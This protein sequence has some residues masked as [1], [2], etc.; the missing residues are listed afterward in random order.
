MIKNY[1]KVAFRILLRNKV[2]S[3]I[4]IVGL[5]VGLCSSII[6]YLYVAH[7]LSFEKFHQDSNLIYRFIMLEED[8][9]NV[10]QHPYCRLPLSPALKNDFPEI[11]ESVRVRWGSIDIAYQD[12]IFQDIELRYVDSSFLNVFSF[13]MFQGD[14][15]NALK[16]PTSLVL[17]E[18]KA[19]AIFGSE[20]PM[21]KTVR[22]LSGDNFVVRG[23]IQDPPA[24]TKF[25]FEA[26]A[27]V[28]YFK[29]SYFYNFSWNGG[30]EFNTF[31][32]LHKNTNVKDLTSKFKSF[33]EKHNKDEVQDGYLQPVRDMHLHSSGLDFSDGEKR[34]SEVILFAVIALFILF[35]AI[36]NY[37]NL[38]TARSMERA[39]E[40]GI[41]KVVGAH[42]LILIRQFFAESYLLVLLSVFLALIFVEIFLPYVNIVLKENLSLYMRSSINVV[43]ILIQFFIIV[44][45]LSA[46]YPAIYLSSFNPI[47]VLKG[48][49]SSKAKSKLR[50]VLV[51]FQFLIASVLISVTLYSV[52]QLTFILSKDK[53]YSD[54]NVVVVRLNSLELRNN[55][56]DIKGEMESIPGIVKTSASSA[57]PGYGFTA[58][59][60]VPE[61]YTDYILIKLLRIDEDYFETMGMEITKG[62]AFSEN[63][64][65]EQNKFIINETLV[66][67]LGWK[68]PIGKTISRNGKKYTVIGVVKDFHFSSLQQKIEPLIISVEVGKY[69]EYFNLNIKINENNQT[70][71]INEIEKIML[72]MDESRIFEHFYLDSLKDNVY[73]QERSFN[74]LFQLFSILAICIA[75]LGLYG[76]AAYT[77]EQRIKEIG[78][79]KALGASVS[80]LL[81][82]LSSQ[83]F[84]VLIISNAIA[85]P[86]VVYLIQSWQD[87]YAYF[88]SISYLDFLIS[89][90]ISMLIAAGIVGFISKKVIKQNPVEALKYE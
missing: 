74:R 7:H 71:T 46:I 50:T 72:R 58:N 11:E 15:L 9:G 35:I 13:E 32:K 85:I 69:F 40:V 12:K 87:N 6:I 52:R 5:A 26:I 76:L 42:R 79:R 90:F 29:D 14:F 30:P 38:S 68:D 25:Q 64:K 65:A 21:G 82:I 78:I 83:Y 41:K 56:K 51:V 60:Y 88:V 75:C 2:F 63:L 19:K 37:I 20:N 73:A 16:D 39:K 57:Y 43:V 89:F 70:E 80:N 59:G 3:F 53:G 48:G 4:N 67:Q 62:R 33:F 77:A 84:N 44:G 10:L 86:L 1:L 34:Y 54:E 18:S 22:S 36:I 28:D 27:S 81:L 49:M 61:G 66:R 55:Y 17:T 47:K 45:G 24:N 23:I 8:N 31:V